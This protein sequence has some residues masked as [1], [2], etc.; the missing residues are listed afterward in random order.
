MI[1]PWNDPL[2]VAEKVSLLDHL[3]GGRAILGLGRGLSRLEYRH[4]GIDMNEA[5]DRF[6]EARA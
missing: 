2:R 3:S 4:F 1:V 5:R 6:D